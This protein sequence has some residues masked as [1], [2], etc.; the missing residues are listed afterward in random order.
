MGLLDDETRWPSHRAG[1]LD[2][3]GPAPLEA[4]ERDQE[5]QILEAWKATTV[6][7]RWT[8]KANVVADRRVERKEL[9]G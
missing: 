8:G 4:Q 7:L 5:A 1:V 9:Q 3:M 2:E 6:K